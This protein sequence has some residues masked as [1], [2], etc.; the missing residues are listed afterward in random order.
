MYGI[1]V[2]TMGVP[3]KEGMRR[4]WPIREKKGGEREGFGMTYLTGR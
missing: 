3:H 4:K 2:L 1:F